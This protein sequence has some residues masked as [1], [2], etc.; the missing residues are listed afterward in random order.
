MNIRDAK[1]VDERRALIEKTLGIS[2]ESVGKLIVDNPDSIHC[3]N[4]IGMFPEV[5]GLSPDFL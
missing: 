2:L 3:E 1:T 5:T 4:L